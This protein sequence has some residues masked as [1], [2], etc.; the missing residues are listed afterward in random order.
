MGLYDNVTANSSHYVDTHAALPLEELQRSTDELNQKYEAGINNEDAL[1]GALAQAT[2]GP[3]KND[4]AILAQAKDQISKEA[5]LRAAAGD[6]EHMGRSVAL[7][8]RKFGSIYGQVQSNAQ[9]LQNYKQSLQDMVDSTNPNVHIDKDKMQK[10]LSMS[11]QQYGDGLQV[12]PK[13]GKLT[14]F[15]SGYIPSA[16]YD[17]AGEMAKM[18]KDMHPMDQEI[19]HSVMDMDS[20]S[21]SYGQSVHIVDGVKILSSARVQQATQ[22]AIRA[23]PELMAD[24]KD[25][26]YLDAASQGQNASRQELYRMYQDVKGGT[27][28]IDKL[29]SDPNFN[30]VGALTNEKT[31][32]SI[33]N[34]GHLMGDIFQQREIK[35]DDTI[36]GSLLNAKNADGSNLTGYTST[37]PGKMAL[38]AV[39]TNWGELTSLVDNSKADVDSLTRKLELA[40]QEQVNFKAGKIGQLD[41]THDIDQITSELNDARELNGIYAGRKKE[42][43]DK[44]NAGL[45]PD[46]RRIVARI[47]KL[48][49]SPQAQIQRSVVQYGSENV[50]A[51]ATPLETDPRLDKY[52]RM[53]K[54]ENKAGSVDQNFLPMNKAREKF[55][56]DHAQDLVG[57][58]A[59]TKYLS[60]GASHDAGQ[61]IMPDEMA[62]LNKKKRSTG[63]GF[64]PS[65]GNLTHV[66]SAERQDPKT[67]DISTLHLYT[68]VPASDVQ[69]YMAENGISEGMMTAQRKAARIDGPKGTYTI[70]PEYGGGSVKAEPT[71]GYTLVLPRRDPKTDAKVGGFQRQHLSRSEMLSTM[72]N[73]YNNPDGKP[74]Q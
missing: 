35:H 22:E 31:N 58:L 30:A 18:M 74:K 1:T 17:I 4:Q 20:R 25:R 53:L 66:W 28:L 59:S 26:A 16:T 11:M 21:P 71:G 34:I 7:S 70:A 36:G 19:G 5:D 49:M 3:F 67:K 42:V 48:D 52:N 68:D 60:A 10:A 55:Y 73:V 37:I 14:N 65:N 32:R 29:V 24:L 44:V 15:F 38:P 27:A 69:A 57:T 13:T 9:G 2:A 46:E 72:A 47:G 64:N 50:P 39:G 43:E 23:R 33:G 56:N 63:M 6:Y 61:E 62:A 8:A 45:N 54:A 40:N 51:E 12:D 41:R